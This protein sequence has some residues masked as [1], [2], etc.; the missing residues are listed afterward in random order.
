[1]VG[2]SNKFIS[3]ES[4]QQFLWSIVLCVDGSISQ[5]LCTNQQSDR[6]TDRW[7]DGRTQTELDKKIRGETTGNFSPRVSEICR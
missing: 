7:T 3:W 6:Q 4:L 1:M 2:I 5:L